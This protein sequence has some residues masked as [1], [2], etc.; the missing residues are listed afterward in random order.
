MYLNAG[1]LSILSCPDSGAASLWTLIR[2]SQAKLFEAYELTQAKKDAC[3]HFDHELKR[4]RVS[5]D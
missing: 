1:N 5:S 3:Q 4:S 2:Q